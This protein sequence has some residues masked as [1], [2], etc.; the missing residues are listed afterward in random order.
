MLTHPTGGSTKDRTWLVAI[1]A[2]MWGLDG[3]LRKPL[4]TTLHP[5]TVV[6]W[7]HLIAVVAV[8]VFL[9]SA[10][11]AFLGCSWRDRVVIAAI[12]I[13]ASA[14]G[15]A[16]F[17][18]AFKLASATGDFVTPLVLQKQQPLFAVGLAVL[19]LRE[20]LRPGFALYA[21]PALAG[22][23]LLTF[24]D[25][26]AVKIAAVKVALFALGAA[27]LWASGTVLGRL[28]SGAVSARDLTVLRF[29]WGLVGAFAINWKLNAPMTP[30]WGNLG[31]LVLLALIPGLLALTLYYLGLRYTAASRATFAELA[32]PATAAIV[33]VGFLGARLSSSQW[34]GFALVLAAIV[35]LGWHER[36]REPA[37][38]IPANVSVGRARSIEA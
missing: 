6:L 18:E 23:W 12:G 35:G 25:P 2:A 7:E 13:G 17:T 34:F 11:R 8:A 5:S 21:V 9:P 22:A 24:A 32:F 19:I 27:V 29:V 15:I 31:G 20:R 10:V 14:T 3:L 26:F 36:V 33:G 30:G 38:Q 37:V 1:A 4:A 16:L 28:V